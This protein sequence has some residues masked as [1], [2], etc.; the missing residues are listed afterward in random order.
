MLNSRKKLFFIAFSLI[1]TAFAS[2][3]GAASD[4]YRVSNVEVDA[5]ASTAVRAREEAILDGH[6]TALNRLLRRLSLPEDWPRLPKLSGKDARLLSI[7]YSMS[8]VSNSATRYLGRISVRFVPQRVQELLRKQNISFGDV[9]ASSAL[10]VPVYDLSN[11]RRLVWDNQNIW[12]TAWDRP[13]IGENLTPF[14]LP[15]GD[16][17]DILSLPA[18]AAGIKNRGGLFQLAKRYNA[19]RILF[20]HAK[21]EKVNWKGG[22]G[23]ALKVKLYLMTERSNPASDEVMQFAVSGADDPEV[24]AR[25]GVS[26]ILRMTGIAWKRR[27]II[28]HDE[29]SEHE[30]T[31]KFRSLLEWQRVR[32][33]LDSVPVLKDLQILRL[34]NNSALLKLNF[35]GSQE[36]LSL[37]LRQKNIELITTEDNETPWQLKVKK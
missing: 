33:L 7:G 11:G 8:Q 15:I 12:R 32:K 20:A 30:A 17:D 29:A 21:L 10:V 2:S 18:K 14:A 19:N 27:I 24:L 16:I 5:T 26:D 6:A 13:D 36:V 9:Q 1:L 3:Q 37:A 25:R 22:V 34:D 31:I 35:T 28:H 23:Y 4:V